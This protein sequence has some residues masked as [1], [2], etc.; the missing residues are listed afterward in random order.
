MK[1]DNERDRFK[2][3]FD[4][5]QII[6]GVVTKHEGRYIIID[7]DGVAFDPQK[8]LSVLEGNEIRL[9]MVRKEAMEDIARLVNAA[10][11]QQN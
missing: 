3:G 5:G 8:A 10:Q 9:T 7:E 6:D 2:H 11:E 4:A 1:F